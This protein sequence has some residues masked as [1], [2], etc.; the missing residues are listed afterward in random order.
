MACGAAE[1]WWEHPAQVEAAAGVE[2]GESDVG[3]VP[4]FTAEHTSSL[5]AGRLG[6]MALA[7]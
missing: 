7:E 2:Y 4:V 3:D 6:R 5:G 1:A